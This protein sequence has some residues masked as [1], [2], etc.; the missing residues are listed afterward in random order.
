MKFGSE[1][2]FI[3][4]AIF[5]RFIFCIL[6]IDRLFGIKHEFSTIITN[7]LKFGFNQVRENK[8]KNIYPTNIHSVLYSTNNIATLLIQEVAKKFF[9]RYD[10]NFLDQVLLESNLTY[11]DNMIKKGY[12]NV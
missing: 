7:D 4:Q 6:S 12:N 5:L 2:M 3:K 10:C 11:F 8:N 1:K 9:N